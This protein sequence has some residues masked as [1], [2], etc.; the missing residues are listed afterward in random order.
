[1]IQKTMLAVCAAFVMAG[2][3]G[4]SA[5]EN[6]PLKYVDAQNFRMINKG[7]SPLTINFT[8]TFERKMIPPRK[9]VARRYPQKESATNRDIRNKKV[10]INLTLG[11]KRC[12][13]ESAG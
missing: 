9:Q 13:E 3:S 5:Q 10:P 1:M 7:F 2:A 8:G 6:G 11:S 12:R 4:L